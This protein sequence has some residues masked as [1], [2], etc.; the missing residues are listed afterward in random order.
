L[1]LIKTHNYSE[2]LSF[3]WGARVPPFSSEAQHAPQARW[4]L[5]KLGQA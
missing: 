2:L 4:Q 5:T 3:A 1:I